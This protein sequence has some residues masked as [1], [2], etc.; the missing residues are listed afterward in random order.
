MNIQIN[1]LLL[2]SITLLFLAT[3]ISFADTFEIIGPTQKVKGEV[4]SFWSDRYT[5]R[6][7]RRIDRIDFSNNVD[8]SKINSAR[9]ACPSINKNPQVESLQHFSDNLIG[10]TTNQYWAGKARTQ[11]INALLEGQKEIAQILGLPSST[12]GI[13]TSCYEKLREVYGS[14]VNLNQLRSNV[15]ISFSGSLANP[16]KQPRLGFFNINGQTPFTYDEALYFTKTPK[17]M[18]KFKSTDDQ[19]VGRAVQYKSSSNFKQDYPTDIDIVITSSR[20]SEKDIIQ[21]EREIYEDTGVIIDI[22]EVNEG[23]VYILNDIKLKK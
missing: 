23:T 19:L 9:Q 22:S 17:S 3:N 21:I 7:S 4:G 20:Y 14:S 6:N 2:K 18:V 1:D 8:C 10:H 13:P 11:R 5:S 12:V 15:K 16:S